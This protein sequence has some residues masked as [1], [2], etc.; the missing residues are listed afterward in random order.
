M[1]SLKRRYTPKSDNGTEVKLRA[2]THDLVE[3]IKELNCLYGI[4]RLVE[5]EHTSLD[6]ILQGVVDLMPPA[7]QYPEAT[8]ACINLKHKRF[9]T[10][11][12]KETGWKQAE[13]IIVNGKQ[14]GSVEVYYL[15]EEP[16]AYEGPFLKEERDLI[17]GIAERLGHIMESRNAEM[18]LQKSYLREKR[19]SRKLQA[20]MQKR[21]DFTRQLVHEL[22]TPLTSLLA[23][24]QLLSEETRGTRLEKLTGYV[25]DGANNL[26]VRIDELHDV[27]R[28]EIGKLKVVPKS[29]DICR[30][31]R[32][33]VEETR[34]LSRQ[35]GVSIKLELGPGL[36]EVYADEERV[37]QIMFNLINN[38]CKYASEGKKINIRASELAGAVQIEV[39]DKG[40]GMTALKRRSIFKPGYQSH[41]QGEKSGGLG[42]G[43]PLCKMLVE[44]HGGKMRLESVTGKGSSFFFTLPLSQGRHSK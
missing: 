10:G 3:R 20:E 18:A 22:K 7:W 17:H 1:V 9:R 6:E 5:N 16:F 4:S 26:N 11:N 8:C 21:V 19:L 28:G 31:L 39:Q 27:I 42:I 43:L 12:L 30:L 44:L 35:H 2:L 33:I 34:A 36:P 40:P 13:N 25:W 14:V 15:E 32:S 41:D 29:L 37:R 24:S 23:T 38:A